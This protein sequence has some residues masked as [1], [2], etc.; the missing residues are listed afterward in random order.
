MNSKDLVYYKH[1][2]GNIKSLGYNF[3]N[4]LLEK[5]L[6]ASYSGGN[7]NVKKFY[8]NIEDY[9]LPTTLVLLNKRVEDINKNPTIFDLYDDLYN[10]TTINDEIQDDGL[11]DKLLNIS[12]FRK[13]KTRKN[14][15]Q[16][17]KYTRKKN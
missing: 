15:K 13:S 10:S 17:K 14:R 3:K 2:D 4:L 12:G 11:Y 8:E 6:P 16:S 1:T 5:G 9:S 7:K